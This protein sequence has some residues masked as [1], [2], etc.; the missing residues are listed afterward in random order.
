MHIFIDESG[1]IK[2]WDPSLPGY[3]RYFVIVGIMIKEPKRIAKIVKNNLFG[4]D[5]IKFSQT[6]HDIRKRV[7][8]NIGKLEDA[9]IRGIVVDKESVEDGHFKD[10]PDIFYYWLTK[11]LFKLFKE[12]IANEVTVCLDK[13]FFRRK[14]YDLNR[15]IL[16]TIKEFAP[17][18]RCIIQHKDS[19]KELCLSAIDVVAGA[20][21]NEYMFGNDK[22]SRFIKDKTKTIKFFRK[23]GVKPP[24]RQTSSD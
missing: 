3:S 2:N 9:K 1:D 16:N 20:V 11:H 14:R 12:E 10:N 7:L 19:K 18:T 22:Y 23:N 13:R 17:G 15:S 21:R 4:M 8:K 5:E 24:N 6:S